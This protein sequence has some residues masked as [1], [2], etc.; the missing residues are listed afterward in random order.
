MRLRALLL[1]AGRGE[2]L[3]PLSLEI[4]KPLLPVA[5]RTVAERSLAAL[6]DA[7]CRAIA[8]NLHHLGGA[9]RARLGDSFRGV[10]I[11]YSHETELQGTRG[12]LAPL[13]EFFAGADLALVVNGDSLC[14]WPLVDLVR[15]HLAA[16]R[17]GRGPAATLL[18]QRTADPRP[19]GG[20]V[21]IE[22]GEIVAFRREDL[23][24]V[25]AAEHRVFAGA[26]VVEPRLLAAIPDGPGEL[27]AG[28]YEPLLE[29][30][31]RLAT[32]A[33]AR[34]WHDLGTPARYLTGALDLGRRGLPAGTS[35]VVA[36][37]EVAGGARLAR[38][39]VEAGAK[40]GTRARLAES[41][42]LPGAVVGERARLARVIVGPGVELAAGAEYSDVLLTRG[43]GD[44]LVATQLF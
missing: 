18:V 4:P 24:W 40:I 1:A 27:I 19:F 15:A 33:T 41:L 13:R 25:G 9:I 42:V 38:S 21:A 23:A 35:R 34:P 44:G 8:V 5:G 28:F 17:G 10:P 20:G 16:R 14:A 12:A 37:A 11:T 2:R 3:R 32:F 29:A 22:R 6:A 26:Q 7:G 31:E 39:L 43:V 36:G 30:G